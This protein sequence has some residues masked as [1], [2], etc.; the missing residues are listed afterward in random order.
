VV[1]AKAI[2][3]ADRAP[4]D[5]DVEMTPA[6]TS[7]T[8]SSKHPFI[9]SKDDPSRLQIRLVTAEMARKYASATPKEISEPTN[10][11]LAFDGEYVNASA[12]L[13]TPGLF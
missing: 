2:A 8:S 11:V 1:K 10:S 12:T 9:A 5:E 7:N 13:V 3:T 4:V 6:S